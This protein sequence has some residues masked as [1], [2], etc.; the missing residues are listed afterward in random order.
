LLRRRARP[1][2]VR[3]VDRARIH[4]RLGD[5]VTIPATGELLW[6]TFEIEPTLAGRLLAT[7]YKVPELH[8]SVNTA[9]GERLG[10]RIIRSTAAAG[11]LLSPVVVGPHDFAAVAAG[12]TPTLASRRVNSLVVTGPALYRR[13]YTITLRAIQ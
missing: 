5:T 6:A 3:F 9:G 4:A 13:D 7:L 12:R 1:V 10:G 11:F 8:L 2:P